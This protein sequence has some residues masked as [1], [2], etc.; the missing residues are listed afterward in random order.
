MSQPNRGASNGVNKRKR[1]KES[2]RVSKKIRISTNHVPAIQLVGGNLSAAGILR[3]QT[4]VRV[5][6][7]RRTDFDRP[8]R[9]TKNWVS[10][11][12]DLSVPTQLWAARRL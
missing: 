3:I 5:A 4:R 7:V 2:T 6:D 11:L 9:V 12:S 8:N 1:R 10:Y